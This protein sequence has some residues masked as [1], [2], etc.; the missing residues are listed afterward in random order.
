MRR[1]GIHYDVGTDT[2]EGG[3]TRD[4]LPP[5]VIERE[6]RA[7]AYDLHATAV[8]VAG[9]DPARLALA[10]QIAA[11]HG[12]DVW[13]SPMLP[14]GDAAATLAQL[15]ETARAGEALRRQGHAVVLVVGCELSGFM[16]GIIPGKDVPSRLALLADPGRLVATVSAAGYDPRERFAAHLQRA[17]E[18]ARERFRGPLTYASGTWEEVD[19]GPFDLVGVDAY[20]DEG[21]RATYAERLRAYARHGKPVVVTEFGCATFRGAAGR[22]GL[23]WQAVDRD[24]RPPRLREGIVRDEAAQ[25]QELTALLETFERAGLDGA[26]VFTYVAPSYPS[27]AD[28]AHDLDAASFGLVRSWPDGRTEPKEAFRAVAAHY[29]LAAGRA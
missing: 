14:N 5:A 2:V 27:S 26:F 11:G 4:A 23:A 25:A 29:A 22:G 9:H 12:L 10:G 15:D 17:V 19:W 18:T 8:R 1:R 24:A 6:L 16:A 20:R 21:A 7:V 3:T 13:F 28:P